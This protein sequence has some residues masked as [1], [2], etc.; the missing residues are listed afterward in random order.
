VKPDSERFSAQS[1]RF[2]LKAVFSSKESIPDIRKAGLR[3]ETTSEN[4]NSKNY[5]K[6]LIPAYDALSSIRAQLPCAKISPNQMF[7]PA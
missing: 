1:G 5:D 2:A 7:K 6:L 3:Y 4:D